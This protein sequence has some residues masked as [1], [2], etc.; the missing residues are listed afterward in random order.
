MSS[1]SGP[2][3]EFITGLTLNSLQWPRLEKAWGSLQEKAAISMWAIGPIFLTAGHREVRNPN[4]LRD[5]AIIVG[6]YHTHTGP[7][8]NTLIIAGWLALVWEPATTEIF[9]LQ[10][11]SRARGPMQEPTDRWSGIDSSRIA[12]SFSPILGLWGAPTVTGSTHI[13]GLESWGIAELEKQRFLR[14]NA[15]SYTPLV[16]AWH[17][18]NGENG[19]KHVR[20]VLGFSA[21]PG[22][23]GD[24]FLAA[25]R[26]R[27]W[28]FSPPYCIRTPR[29]CIRTSLY[30]IQIAKFVTYNGSPR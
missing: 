16:P 14:P 26:A 19:E 18:G 22:L 3:R 1:V 28:T 27:S 13:T 23:T 17:L 20:G 8:T 2:R 4:S 12:I 29:Y 21:K 15:A 11:I 6:V 24:A 30:C 7:V 5:L 10:G 25:S 9:P